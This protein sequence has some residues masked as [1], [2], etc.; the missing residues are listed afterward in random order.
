MKPNCDQNSRN[1]TEK[2]RRPAG[3]LLP[4][5]LKS[6]RAQKISEYVVSILMVLLATVLR[7]RLDPVLG[8]HHPFTSYFGAVA[9][10]SW[11]GGFG[12]GMLAIALS[13]LG[14]DW[15]SSSRDRLP[16]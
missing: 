15:F 1:R 10:A 13:Y 3:L 2:L 7:L 8:E 5:W 4:G 6:Q 9:I 11:Y 14:A 16:S 12:P